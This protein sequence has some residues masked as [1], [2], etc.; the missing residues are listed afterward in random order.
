MAHARQQIRAA[1][2]TAV[3]GLTTTGTRVHTWRAYELA[4]DGL[5]ALLVSTPTEDIDRQAQ[6][7]KAYRNMT[8]ECTAVVRAASTAYNTADTIAAEVEA[9]ILADET[10]GGLA[11]FCRL[12]G[13]ASEIDD[14]A[15]QPTFQIT[16]TFDCMY[17]VD[18]T[19]P[20]TIVT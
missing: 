5:P 7:T 13:T 9:A 12:T 6:G 3:T 10:L 17:R 4:E 20:E 11:R 16:L 2:A 18:D 8:I 19:D 15:Q 14:E 1:F